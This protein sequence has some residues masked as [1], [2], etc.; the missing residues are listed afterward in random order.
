MDEAQIIE[1]LME[2]GNSVAVDRE[3]TE[4]WTRKD[5]V[6]KATAEKMDM[7]RVQRTLLKNEFLKAFKK[8][9]DTVKKETGRPLWNNFNVVKSGVAFNGSSTWMFHDEISDDDF[10]KHKQKVGDIDITVP[11]DRMIDLFNVLLKY[12]DKKFGNIEYIG[13][14]RPTP[15]DAQ[16]INAVF[17]F[18]VPGSDYVAY[19]QVDF[20]PSDYENDAP[21][22]WDSFSHNSDWADIK[23]GF[24]G[25]NHKYALTIMAHIVSKDFTQLPTIMRLSGAD[26]KKFLTVSVAFE[27]KINSVTM[28]ELG[29]QKFDSEADFAEGVLKA[30]LQKSAPKKI[31]AVKNGVTVNASHYLAFS[32]V[33]GLRVK[34]RSLLTKDNKPIMVDGKM[35]LVALAAKDIGSEKNLKPMFKLFFGY[36]PKSS[37]IAKM[38]SFVGVIELLKNS[39]LPDRKK[40]YEQFLDELIIEKLWGHSPFHYDR[41]QELERD[42]KDIDA[43]IKW[44]MVNYIMDELKVGNLTEI[45]KIADSYYKTWEGGADDNI[46]ESFISYGSKFSE[47]FEVV[48]DTTKGL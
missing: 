46:R 44:S 45:K 3:K 18:E 10:T 13:N 22:E 36:E 9:N 20:E 27:K 30:K 43:K 35:V 23:K 40:D 25:V 39:K 28:K 5:Q 37:D 15:S 26:K 24:K 42:S 12:E 33:K 34:Y 14:N 29:D 7:T 48:N 4:K 8:L 31:F 16:Q 17:K 19:P 47:I 1:M 2:G 6:V 38:K 21:T 41:S 32:V 11:K